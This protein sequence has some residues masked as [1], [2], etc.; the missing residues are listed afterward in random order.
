MRICSVICVPRSCC[1]T[2]VSGTS[3]G[4]TEKIAVVFGDTYSHDRSVGTCHTVFQSG[5]RGKGDGINLGS[6]GRVSVDDQSLCLVGE[7][8]M[9]DSI[10]YFPAKLSG[11]L[12]YVSLI[13]LLPISIFDPRNYFP[14]FLLPNSACDN[15]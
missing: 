14:P 10:A 2:P 7:S 6:L 12:R 11:L 13:N 1:V 15:Q 5:C 9:V 8:T 4:A 3:L